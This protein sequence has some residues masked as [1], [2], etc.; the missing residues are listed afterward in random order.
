MTGLFIVLIIFSVP[1]SA[2]WTEHLRK[3]KKLE[4]AA[5]EKMKTEIFAEIAELR[6]ELQSLRDT[7]TQYDLSFDTA[8]QRLERR[9]EVLEQRSLSGRSQ[10]EPP[11]QQYH[12]TV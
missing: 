7:T 5:R 10:Q 1:L 6:Q 3:V 4:L 2:I 9:V 11:S 12:R 8:L